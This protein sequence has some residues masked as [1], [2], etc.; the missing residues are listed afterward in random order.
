[1]NLHPQDLLDPDL[2]DENSALASMAG[3]VVLEITERVAITDVENARAK[4]LALRKCGFRIAV[5]DLG[6]GYTGLSSFA[7]LEP[8]FVKLDMTL[9]RDIDALTVKQKLVKALAS[10][11]REMGL[12]VVAEGVETHAERDAAVNL[13]CDFLQGYL[14]ARPGRAFPEARW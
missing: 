12:H 14:F 10:S 7:L 2:N 6:A 5:D 13:G 4:V 11:C 1:M 9:I 3:R 8:E